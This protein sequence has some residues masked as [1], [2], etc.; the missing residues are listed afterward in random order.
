M[1]KRTTRSIINSAFGPM[2]MAAAVMASLDALP[3]SGEQA[4][5]APLN[6]A[7]LSELRDLYKKLIEAENLHDLATVKAMLLASPDSLFISRVEPVEKGDWGG[8]W[9]TASIMS[10]FAALYDGTF[11]IDPNYAEQKVVG[12]S[13]DVAETYVPVTITSGYGGQ[14]PVG[15]RFLM[16]LD[17][18]RTSEGW[19]VATDIPM[20]IPPPP[21]VKK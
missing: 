20:P 13:P 16:V 21:S 17:W 5:R 10:H 14:A 11:R 2:L 15:R 4:Y 7:T 9:G 1:F 3:A 6:E 8:Y 12:L 18:V 19:R